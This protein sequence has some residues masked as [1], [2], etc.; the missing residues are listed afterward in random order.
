MEV[1]LARVDQKMHKQRDKYIKSFQVG[2]TLTKKIKEGHERE[3]GRTRGGQG[4]PG[5]GDL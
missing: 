2:L 4:P 5:R 3:C 1:Y